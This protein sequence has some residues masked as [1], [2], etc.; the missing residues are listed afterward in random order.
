MLST[1]KKTSKKLTKEELRQRRHLKQ[2]REI[3]HELNKQ[4]TIKG[5]YRI[6]T[7][8]CENSDELRDVELKIADEKIEVLTEQIRKKQLSFSKK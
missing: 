8:N 2:I 1:T 4:Y 5:F 3:Q 7:V 6:F